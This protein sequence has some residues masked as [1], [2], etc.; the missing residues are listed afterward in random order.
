M[1]KRLFALCFAC[2]VFAEATAFRPAHGLELPFVDLNFNL[3]FHTRVLPGPQDISNKLGLVVTTDKIRGDKRHSLHITGFITNYSDVTCDNVDMRF[4][5]TSYMGTG[6]STGCAAVEPRSIP[7]WGV[8]IFRA[9][10]SL[11]SEKPRDALYTITA[12]SP[13][14]YALDATAAA[15]ATAIISEPTAEEVEVA[16]QEQP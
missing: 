13:L 11:D 14:L 6:V 4:V 2:V 16:E 7:P 15:P 9:H 8:A 10:I 1:K 5:V 3:G 12:Q